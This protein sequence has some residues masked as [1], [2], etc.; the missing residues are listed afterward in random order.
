MILD[1]DLLLFLLIAVVTIYILVIDTKKYIYKIK[2]K[3]RTKSIKE[4]IIDLTI[5]KK[6]YYKGLHYNP[7]VKTFGYYPNLPDSYIIDCIDNDNRKYTINDK[8]IFQL[9][10][11]NDIIQIKLIEKLDKNNQVISRR[12]SKT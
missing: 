2:L 1:K 10:D 4:S 12:V 9:Y 7:G 3:L 6:Y 5:V 8:D 11:I